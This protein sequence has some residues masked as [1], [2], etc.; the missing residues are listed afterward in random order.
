MLQNY[1]V[2][3]GHNLSENTYYSHIVKMIP[4]IDETDLCGGEP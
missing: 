2:L 4:A 1:L 3:S